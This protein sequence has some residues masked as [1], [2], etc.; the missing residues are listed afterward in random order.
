MDTTHKENSS[1]LEEVDV[2]VGFILGCTCSSLELEDDE[3]DA[4]QEDPGPSETETASAA[5]KPDTF[6]DRI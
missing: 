4:E 3:D 2:E 6:A 5:S 1:L